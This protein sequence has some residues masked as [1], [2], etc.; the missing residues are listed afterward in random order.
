LDNTDVPVALNFPTRVDSA[1]GKHAGLKG[2]VRSFGTP[3]EADT[4]EINFSM[5]FE[6]ARIL[7]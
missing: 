5:E 6:V 1:A 2:F 4:V 3:L 7:P